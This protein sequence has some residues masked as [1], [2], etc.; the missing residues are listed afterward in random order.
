MPGKHLILAVDSHHFAR[1]PGGI[2]C[3]IPNA[4]APAEGA[5]IAP[6]GAGG[7]ESRKCKGGYRIKVLY[8]TLLFEE[9][10]RRSFPKLQSSYHSTFLRSFFVS[11]RP[12][13]PSRFLRT[14]PRVG[15]VGRLTFGGRATRRSISASR[16]RQISLLR[17]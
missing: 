8:G 10:A 13:L 6:R 12:S 16:S 5:W 15:F 4:N 2:Y 9:R 17:F 11:E 1:V 14:D 3:P 7:R